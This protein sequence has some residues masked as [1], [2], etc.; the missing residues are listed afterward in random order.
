MDLFTF[1]LHGMA[2][3]FFIAAPIG[4]IGVLCIR[5]TFVRGLKAGL[6]SG[7][8]A[9]VAD[10]FYGAVG[11][12]GLT[13]ISDF[14][15]KEKFWLR[16]IGGLFLIYLGV[17]SFFRKPRANDIVLDKGTASSDFISTLFC[18]LTNPMTIVAYS[19][20]FVTLGEI[21][22]FSVLGA[23]FLTAGVTLGAGL[24]WFILAVSV[25]YF[26]RWFGPLLMVWVNRIAALIIT[27]FGVGI[28]ASLFSDS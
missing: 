2:I 23:S 12:F 16:L 15:L 19:A 27:G 18:T 10:G 28:I 9:T 22:S 7:L 11:A 14:L 8:G 26:R 6:L 5:R 4:P 17:K 24:W 13:L 20:V 25:A 21:S 3:G 1:L